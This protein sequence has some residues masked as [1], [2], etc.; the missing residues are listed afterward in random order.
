MHILIFPVLPR[1]KNLELFFYLY[2]CVFRVL[3]SEVIY[4]GALCCFQYLPFI[5]FG[6][7]YFFLS[8]EIYSQAQVFLEDE[9][10]YPKNKDIYEAMNHRNK[11][12]AACFVKQ[13]TYKY[14]YKGCV[15]NF[16]QA[17]IS[18]MHKSE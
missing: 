13:V 3:E 9:G 16:T 15:Q 4:S 12:E 5:F 11:R 17:S 10:N 8:I 14:A 6:F 2:R 7:T 18:C 1:F